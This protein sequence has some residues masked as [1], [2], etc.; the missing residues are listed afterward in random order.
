MIVTDTMKSIYMD[1]GFSRN[2]EKFWDTEMHRAR[3]I[4]EKCSRLVE[5]IS[6]IFAKLLLSQR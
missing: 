2:Y 4:S 5:K 3:V 6:R 1:C